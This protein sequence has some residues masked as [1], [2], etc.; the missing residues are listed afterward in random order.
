[1]QF[2]VWSKVFGQGKKFL[3]CD[4][5]Y[6]RVF[7]QTKFSD[8][9][10]REPNEVSEMFCRFKSNSDSSCLMS[11]TQHPRVP[12][13][14]HFNQIPRRFYQKSI[15]AQCP[16]CGHCAFLFSPPLCLCGQHQKQGGALGENSLA[17]RCLL[18]A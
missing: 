5:F 18:S 8:G 10:S 14:A 2:S 11:A 9:A 3:V 15:L 4:G 1:M 16:L 17:V 7:S 12:L 6:N 13:S